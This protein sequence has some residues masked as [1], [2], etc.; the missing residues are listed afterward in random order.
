MTKQPCGTQKADMHRLFATIASIAFAAGAS[1]QP[2]GK[3]G[4]VYPSKPVRVVV[5]FAPGGSNDIMARITAQKFTEALGQQF[6][7]DNRA[8]A[9]GIIGTD[10]AAKAAPDGYTLLVMSLTLTVLAIIGG[11]LVL[12]GIRIAHTAERT[13]RPIV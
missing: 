4:G 9:S 3:P 10:I 13:P 7:V 8:G 12:T 2:A 6:I 11:L 1:A 5:P